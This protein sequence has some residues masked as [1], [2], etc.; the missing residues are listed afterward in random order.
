[1]TLATPSATAPVEERD[2]R[3]GVM[4]MLVGF[5][6]FSILNALVKSLAETFAVNQI[7]FFRNAL[8]LVTL[9]LMARSLGGA[10]AL[11]PLDRR[12]LAQQAL[13]F[14]CVLTFAFIGF[15]NLPLADATA[16]SFL[17]P[18]LV[19]V[20]SAPLLGEKVT[21]HGWIAL[22]IGLVG[23]S[24]VVQPTGGGSAFGAKMALCAAVF[25]SLSLIQQRSLSRRDTSLAIVFWTLAG[26]A[27]IIAPTLPY[28][29]V[30]PT[31]AQWALL[32]GNGLASGF[33]Q[34]LTTRAV[35]HAP[36]GTLAPLKYTGMVWAIIIGFVWFGDLPGPVVILGSLL[37]MAASLAA[38]M[39]P[40]PVADTGQGG[41]P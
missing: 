22:A 24:L 15:R 13:L 28:G 19:L 7:I 1:M 11:R 5:G 25:G 20:L 30:N 17:T 29:W 31:P 36:V 12:G 27:L 26:S 32:I 18:I 9:L 34:Y 10:A 2:A 8:A 21:R 38:Y 40:R 3:R 41:A 6:L 35:Y 23:V 37:V 16:I 39:T 14:T 33:C 4:M